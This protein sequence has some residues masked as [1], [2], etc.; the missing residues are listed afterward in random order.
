MTTATKS[1][2]RAKHLIKHFGQK[3]VL[4]DFSLSIHEG[5]VVG[6]L[7]PN[8]AGKTTTFH[9]VMGLIQPDK[10]KIF[11]K[12]N[13]VSNL[14][15]HRRARLG[16]GYLSQE[17]SIFRHLTVEEN[18]L[19]ILE[20]LNL[21]KAERMERLQSALDEM[22][23]LSLAKQK[24]SLLSGGEKRRV[25]ISKAL[26]TNP[27][28]L[29]LDEPFANVDPITISDVKK[30]IGYLKARG[31]SILVTDH[32]ARE[33]FSL[34]DRIYLIRDGSLLATG[35]PEELINN[36]SVREK[37]LGENFHL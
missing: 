15:I 26:V 21:S 34:V 6:L 19:C 14:P 35:T 27:S 5:E 18:I 16:M 17:P 20:T 31:I 22:N 9:I 1:L 7:G 24:A 32:N 8:G 29:L 36:P 3:T 4:N 11:F 25:E 2:F 12:D 10:G 37:Y 23:L 30:T 33:I 28:L 13:D